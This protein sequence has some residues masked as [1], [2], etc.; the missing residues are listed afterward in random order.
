MF[1]GRA[2]QATLDIE[3]IGWL[4]KIPEIHAEPPFVLMQPDRAS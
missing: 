4:G 2:D 1:A 3:A